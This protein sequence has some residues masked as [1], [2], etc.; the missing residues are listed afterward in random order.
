MTMGPEESEDRSQKERMALPASKLTTPD[1]WISDLEHPGNFA[2]NE[3][4]PVDYD[5]RR[6]CVHAR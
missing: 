2:N 5:H 3:L 4:E 1:S 6:A